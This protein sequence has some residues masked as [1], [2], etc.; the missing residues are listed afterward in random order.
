L[1]NQEI[2]IE[3]TCAITGHRFIKEDIDFIELKE[4]FIDLIK[5]GID[6]YLIGMAVGFDTLCYKILEKLKEDYQ[7]K[8]VACVPCI[9]QDRNFTPL[10]KK[11]YRDMLKKA[12]VTIYVSTEYTPYCMQKRNMFM[13][14]N[15]S[16]LVS[17]LRENKGGT[18]NTVK[19][20]EKNKKKIIRI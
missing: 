10:Q 14:D 8:L 15:S 3:K 1:I 16:V 7:I 13:V 20:A 9:N 11:V 4:V 6:T 5:K 2:I 18:Y 12:D 17:Y 19:Y